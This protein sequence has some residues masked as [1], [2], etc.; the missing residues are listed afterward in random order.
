MILLIIEWIISIF[1]FS[2]IFSEFNII[3]NMNSFFY[4]IKNW[5][6]EQFKKNFDFYAMWLSSYDIKLKATLPSKIYL[7]S[8]SLLLSNA[9]LAY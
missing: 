7:N 5:F 9:W 1:I 6:N 4:I 3:Y 2:I 8:I